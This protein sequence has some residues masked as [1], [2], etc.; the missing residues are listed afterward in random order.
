MTDPTG[1]FAAVFFDFGGVISPEGFVEGLAVLARRD[2]ADPDS[3]VRAAVDIMYT[4]GY[5]VGRDDEPGYWAELRARTGLTHSDAV[6]RREV[7]GR[8]K[9]RPWMLE[10]AGAVRELGVCAAILSDH[11]LWLEEFDREQ[12]FFR[13]FDV[14]INSFHT[15]LTKRQ[16]ECFRDALERVNVADPARAL[17][18]D[19]AR[20]NVATARAAGLSA[21][22]CEEARPCLFGLA[23]FLPGLAPLA[24]DIAK[25]NPLP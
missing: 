19:D 10:L 7:L 18:L 4:G 25:R 24:G 16:P 20:V 15:G 22:L 6:F 14:V 13:H 1:G 17:L 5:L 21:V 12:D 9:V 11:T 2:G 3:V 8:I 23:E